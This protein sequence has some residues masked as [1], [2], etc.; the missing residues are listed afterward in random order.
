MPNL[1]KLPLAN[2][3][4]QSEALREQYKLLH[5]RRRNRESAPAGDEVRA[6]VEAIAAD[7]KAK[8]QQQAKDYEA[9][10]NGTFEGEGVPQPTPE[11]AARLA[12]QK[13][14]DGED[15]EAEEDKADKKPNATPGRQFDFEVREGGAC[16]G[17]CFCVC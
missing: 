3:W 1:G 10:L 13:D 5:K 15:G 12:A 2:Y 6:A 17:A 16:G 9:Y 4:V 8:L 7:A 14:E 11:Q